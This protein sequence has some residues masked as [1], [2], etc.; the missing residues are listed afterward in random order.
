M[1]TILNFE[2]ILCVSKLSL[3]NIKVYW[4]WWTEYMYVKKGKN[5]LEYVKIRSTT[6][7]GEY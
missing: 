2:S 6:V 7:N 5:T 3:W 1:D 4:T